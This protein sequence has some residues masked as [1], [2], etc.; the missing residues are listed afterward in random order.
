M[1][2]LS[3]LLISVSLFGVSFDES[4]NPRYSD[5]RRFDEAFFKALYEENN[6]QVVKATKEAQ[7][8]KVIHQI[9]LGGKLPEKFHKFAASWKEQNPEWEYK[10]WTD[11]DVD[12]FPWRNRKI[13][14]QAGNYGMKSDIWRY[15]ILNLHGGVYADI[16]FECLQSLDKFHHSCEF[17]GGLHEGVMMGNGFFASRSCHPIL[18]QCMREIA[19]ITNFNP[20]PE[21]TF[22][23]TG[24]YFLTRVVMD[25]VK[26]GHRQGV[27]IYP[28]S[29]FF[30]FPHT[31]H[32]KLWTGE[33]TLERL[34]KKFFRPESHAVHY[35]ST[36]WIK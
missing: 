26:N 20:T 24:P 17:Y 7:I 29:Y 10:L 9:W 15:E 13:F 11:E 5:E 32:K 35:W 25:T 30:P 23:L 19:R 33:L 12:K 36:S 34:R 6:Y 1:R 16:D 8:P 22:E 14:D 21:E 31:H 28:T 3:L 2:L 27:V 4:M 18:R